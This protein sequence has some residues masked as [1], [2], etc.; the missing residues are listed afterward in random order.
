MGKGEAPSPSGT[1]PGKAEG[2][3]EARSRID[4]LRERIEAVD[5]ELIRLVG[6]R[7]ELVLEI[8]EL[9]KSVDLPVLDPKR[10]ARVVRRAAAS[11]RAMGV[12]EEMVRDILWRIIASAREAQEGE[13]GWGPPDPPRG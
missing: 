2:G 8:G 6:E 13:R 1:D 3:A 4:G 9:K 10:E 12:E 5:E 11:A 7:R